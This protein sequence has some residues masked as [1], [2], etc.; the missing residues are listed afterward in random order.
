MTKTV[1]GFIN[2]GKKGSYGISTS[3]FN[4]SDATKEVQEKV[5][6]SLENFGFKKSE[7]KNSD[8]LSYSLWVS[9]LTE[10][11]KKR[12]EDATGT[13]KKRVSITL[14]RRKDKKGDTFGIVSIADINTNDTS[15][16][17]EANEKELTY[18]GYINKLENGS[19]ALSTS[20]KVDDEDVE[21]KITLLKAIGYN[22]GESK[23]ENYRS[24][25][26]WLNK[27][28]EYEQ[29]LIKENGRFKYTLKVAEFRDNIIKVDSLI[30]VEEIEDNATDE[31]KNKA[32]DEAEF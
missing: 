9:D 19:I 11:E 32:E 5:I 2:K 13:E 4:G 12:L 3:V 23:N 21:N 24:F 28:S 26:M 15:Y 10:D 18:Y 16:I 1:K 6:A 30:S 7:S 29:E 22:E 14:S 31:D 25:S 8:W 17:M 27:P 20:V